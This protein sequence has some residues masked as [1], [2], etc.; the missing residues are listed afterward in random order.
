MADNSEKDNT[1]ALE[2]P[3][4]FAAQVLKNQKEQNELIKAVD[5][6]LWEILKLLQ[7]KDKPND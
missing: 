4:I 6:K 3:R 5:W 1:S 2:D 7:K